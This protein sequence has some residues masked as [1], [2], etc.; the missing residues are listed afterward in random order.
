MKMTVTGNKA[1]TVTMN[2]K[3]A[4]LLEG[5]TVTIQFYSNSEKTVAVGDALVLTPAGGN[6][7]TTVGDVT[8]DVQF[9]VGHE[10]FCAVTVDFEGSG[11]TDVQPADELAFDLEFKATVTS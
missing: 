6:V 3:I 2:V 4:E 1:Q 7:T 5:A 9:D 8:S 11:L 10:Y